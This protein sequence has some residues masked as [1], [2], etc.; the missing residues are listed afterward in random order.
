MIME[1]LSLGI[2]KSANRLGLRSNWVTSVCNNGEWFYRHF[3]ALLDQLHL[4][5][6]VNSLLRSRFIQATIGYEAHG[7]G[8]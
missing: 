7:G 1:G 6:Q 3:E 4:H 8:R 5:C 2:A